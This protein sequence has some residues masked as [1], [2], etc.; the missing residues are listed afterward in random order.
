MVETQKGEVLVRKGQTMHSSGQ[1]EQHRDLVH[2]KSMKIGG[3]PEVC[4]LVLTMHKC[5]IAVSIESIVFDI[6]EHNLHTKW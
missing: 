2:D 1:M 3:L 4:Y 5:F 6:L